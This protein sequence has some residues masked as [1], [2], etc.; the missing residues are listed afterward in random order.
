MQQ[1]KA[2]K[3]AKEKERLKELPP[4]QQAKAEEREARRA[5]KKKMG[6]IKVQF[7]QFVPNAPH[8]IHHD[9]I[10]ILQVMYG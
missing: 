9:R 5:R 8:S 1:K 10:H 2:E 7:I 4:D 6:K 3:R